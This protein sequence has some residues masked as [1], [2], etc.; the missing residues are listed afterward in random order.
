MA[1]SKQEHIRI[2]LAKAIRF[3]HAR[4]LMSQ[5]F[6][7]SAMAARRFA[8]PASD[9]GVGGL[10][11]CAFCISA[12]IPFSVLSMENNRNCANSGVYPAIRICVYLRQSAATFFGNHVICSLKE[13]PKTVNRRR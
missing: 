1:G 3:V 11:D 6:C 10:L 2:K 13:S 12:G 8:N 4:Y 7:T 5:L 9:S